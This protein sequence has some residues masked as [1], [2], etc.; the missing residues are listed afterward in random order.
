MDAGHVGQNMYLACEAIDVGTC[1]I[2]AYDQEY[3]DQLLKLDGEE[4][5]SIYLAAVGKKR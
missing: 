4:E 3:L 2:G 5:F 1:T